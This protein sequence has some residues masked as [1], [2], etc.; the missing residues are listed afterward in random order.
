MKFLHKIFC[1]LAFASPLVF[2]Q[3][4][5]SDP[6]QKVY[7]SV[8]AWKLDTPLRDVY[9][10]GEDHFFVVP[11]N[12]QISHSIGTQILSIVDPVLCENTTQF[13]DPSNKGLEQRLSAKTWQL[14]K[15]AIRAALIKSS[16]YRSDSP[17][18]Q[19]NI[20]AELR[21]LRYSN[22]MDLTQFFPRFAH[23]LTNRKLLAE[24]TKDVKVVPGFIATHALKRCEF[25][26]SAEIKKNWNPGCEV[27]DASY[28]KL[29]TAYLPDFYNEPEKKLKI[30]QYETESM[31]PGADTD[32][33]EK[34]LRANLGYEV[35]VQCSLKPRHERWMPIIMRQLNVKGAPLVIVAGSAHIVGEYGLLNQL[36]Q[37]GYCGARRIFKLE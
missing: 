18:L 34:V 12:I 3:T 2:A 37:A 32:S 24:I 25:M 7:E 17:E 9:F 22:Y 13:V 36:C 35:M 15:T 20:D 26:E 31:R 21:K 4:P 6:P 28:E 19:K 23:T 30:E 11:K 8:W 29:I 27:D 5:V 33:L 10:L 16:E 1:V 14:L